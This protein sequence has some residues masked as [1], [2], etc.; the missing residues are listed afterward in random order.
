MQLIDTLMYLEERYNE[1][2][3]TSLEFGSIEEVETALVSNDDNSD[4]D[5]DDSD[6]EFSSSESKEGDA[7]SDGDGGDNNSDVD[8]DDNELLHELDR[9]EIAHLRRDMTEAE[10]N[11]F[12]SDDP[13]ARSLKEDANKVK[14][15]GAFSDTNIVLGKRR[16]NTVDY[17]S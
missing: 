15:L 13:V 5:D 11:I 7:D 14:D 10:C 9:N 8:E 16:R 6:S 12:E 4:E 2:N 17:H 1:Q 3:S